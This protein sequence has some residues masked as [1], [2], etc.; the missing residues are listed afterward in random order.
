MS[1][2]IKTSISFLSDDRVAILYDVGGG[3]WNFEGPRAHLGEGTWI[4]EK[5]YPGLVVVVA[6][7]KWFYQ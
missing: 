1:Q 2:I 6:P 5:S 4:N 3:P 7:L